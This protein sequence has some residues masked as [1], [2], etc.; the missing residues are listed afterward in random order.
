MQLS[1]II[2]NYNV[3]YF[4]EQALLSVQKASEGL[5]VEVI[6]IDNNSVDDSVAI[7]RHKFPAVRLIANTVNT[8]FAVANNQ[9]I[10]LSQGKYVLLL[11]PDTVVEEDT[12][13][14]TLAFM[15]T[16]PSAGGL[17]LSPI[18]RGAT[19]SLRG[20]NIVNTVPC[21]GSLSTKTMP[22]CCVTMP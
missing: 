8:G 2:V 15:D 10:A 20:R 12:F 13:R 4:L 7:V 21:P 19:S 17:G 9:G 18:D 6:V 16:H 11:N 14:Q 5:A 3:A 22:L 1:V